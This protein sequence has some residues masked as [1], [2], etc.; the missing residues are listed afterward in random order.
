MNNDLIYASLIND[1]HTIENNNIEKTEYEDMLLIASIFNNIEMIEYL[2]SKN[3]DIN[4]CSILENC[5]INGN[6]DFIKM[7]IKHDAIITDESLHIAVINN[8]NDIFKYLIEISGNVNFKNCCAI[9]H[10]SLNGNIEMVK[11]LIDN[12]ANVDNNAL[13][14]AVCGYHYDVAKILIKHGAVVQKCMLEQLHYYE[15]VAIVKCFEWAGESYDK[16]T[17]LLLKHLKND[18]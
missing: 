10:Y 18:I 4:S 2:I 1:F 17:T 16:L 13:Y 7:L 5:I 11:Y 12:N 3:I 15:Q 6:S 9:E 14:Y 8:Y